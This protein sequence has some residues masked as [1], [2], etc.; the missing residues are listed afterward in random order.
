MLGWLMDLYDKFGNFVWSI[1]NTFVYAMTNPQEFFIDEGWGIV[2]IATI[3]VVAIIL[4]M[5]NWLTKYYPFN[6][7]YLC[8]PNERRRKRYFARK[9]WLVK[10]DTFWF[11]H[12]VPKERWNDYECIIYHVSRHGGFNRFVVPKVDRK[13][14]EYIKMLRSV[15]LLVYFKGLKRN[16]DILSCRVASNDMR[17]KVETAN[18]T[19]FFRQSRR[20]MQVTDSFSQMAVRSNAETQFIQLDRGSIPLSEDDY[21]EFSDEEITMMKLKSDDKD[22]EEITPTMID[23][24]MKELEV[25]E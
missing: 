5:I 2:I 11:R 16:D 4:Y 17:A 15:D 6:K 3:V 10:K 1:F 25:S 8:A 24:V 20:K 22:E 19:F 13:P 12:K 9:I 14:Y 18:E 23:E 7:I 21:T